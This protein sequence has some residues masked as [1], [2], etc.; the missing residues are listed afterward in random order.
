MC[1]LSRV[2]SLH[3]FVGATTFGVQPTHESLDHLLGRRRPTSRCHG[4]SV[5]YLCEVSVIR[6]SSEIR[7]Y[8]CCPSAS[9][10]TVVLV[11]VLMGRCRGSSSG[12]PTNPRFSAQ[13]RQVQVRAGHTTLEPHPP[14]GDFAAAI[15]TTSNGTGRDQLTA[16]RGQEA[17]PG[18]S[19]APLALAVATHLGAVPAHRHRAPPP[20]PVP[21]HI[22][23][24]PATAWIGAGAET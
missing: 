20:H 10:R 15:A 19:A 3:D 2:R 6:S 23:K 17:D 13:P 1:P 12:R 24:Q 21:R 16:P 11:Q 5:I 9:P 8:G 18:S 22:D 14:P 4:E 7:S